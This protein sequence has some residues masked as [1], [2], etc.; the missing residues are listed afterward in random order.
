[1]VFIVEADE[2]IKIRYNFITNFWS[3]GSKPFIDEAGELISLGLKPFIVE[4]G[5]LISSGAKPFIVEAGDLIRYNFKSVLRE[6]WVEA[7]IP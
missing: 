2:L 1:M 5:E 3:S 7:M 6:F 4:A